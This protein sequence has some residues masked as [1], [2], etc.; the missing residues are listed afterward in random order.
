MHVQLSWSF[1]KRSTK[2]TL[3]AIFLPFL[4]LPQLAFKEEIK[5]TK[6]IDWAE[7]KKSGSREWAD[8]ILFALVAAFI[9]RT[10]VFEAFTIPTPSMEKSLRVGD[11]L[12]V[13]KM[14]YGAK[15]PETPLS[16]PLAHHTFPVI[17]TKSYLEWIK[18][19]Y[20]RLPGWREWKRNDP[21]VFNFPEGDTVHVDAQNTTY[22][23]LIK[24][25][26]FSNWQNA[27]A[28]QNKTVEDPYEVY[29]R[30]GHLYESQF[31]KA[32]ERDG[33]L[34]VRPKDKKDN[35][36]KRCVALPGQTMEVREKKMYI[37]GDVTEDPP[38]LQYSYDVQFNK[39][40]NFEE[41]KAAVNN[42]FL[43][44]DLEKKMKRNPKD[45]TQR[46]TLALDQES[47]DFLMSKNV[48]KEITSEIQTGD[49]FSIFPRDHNFWS[50]NGQWNVDNFGP[51]TMPQKGATIDLT[52]ENLPIYKR[53]IDV[54]EEND[55]TVKS[56]KI[57]I[58]GEETSSYT[59]K[60][61]YYWLMGDNRHNSLDSRFWGFV[62]EDHVVGKATF[63][64]LS[65]DQDLGW[66]NGKVRWD[67][68]F[69]GVD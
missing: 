67:R 49:P 18:N 57:F 28:Q 36:I 48:V 15:M 34:I 61:G 42:S 51:I 16:F 54:Y 68:M 58:N 24:Q 14:S 65:L 7:K 6:N 1:G 52:T 39:G 12:F 45:V 66:F 17:N 63:V 59:F 56:G 46:E 69:R 55:L 13:S 62:P 5:Y 31:K 43:G 22:Y 60:M 38:G 11:F 64:W 33:K 21:M 2:D 4:M 44:E 37:N 53:I 41:L 29:Q 47:Y 40:M 26:G 9:I 3:I 25:V 10:F 8:A 32:W 23:G 27:L 19:D 50:K 20:Y 35:Y 30:V